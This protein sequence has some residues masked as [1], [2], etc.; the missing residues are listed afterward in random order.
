VK[1]KDSDGYFSDW[2]VTLTKAN[3]IDNEEVHEDE[4][5]LNPAVYSYAF[6]DSW[7]ADYDMND[8]VLK[9]KENKR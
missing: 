7:Y 8:V 6:E 2:I 5:D 3:R 1:W 9:V 4:P